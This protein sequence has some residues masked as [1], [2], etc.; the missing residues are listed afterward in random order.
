MKKIEPVNLY[1]NNKP[2]NLPEWDLSDLYPGV[3]SQVL[4]ED[5]ER[6]MLNAEKF[7]KKYQTNIAEI[8]G[9]KLAH[10]II[11]FEKIEE[12][13]SRIMSY[14][15]LVYATDMSDSNNGQFYQSMQEAVTKISSKLL[16][17]TLEIN[18]IED[19]ELDKK[20]E[21]PEL[22]HFQAMDP[23]HS[24]FSPSPIE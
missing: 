20:L 18:R 13:I 24:H 9:T 17:F 11:E 1:S 14:A 21:S 15:Q 8:S 19:A 16:F 6:L 7:K 3:K 22:S 10:C 2:A 4:K 23:R 12:N 5:L